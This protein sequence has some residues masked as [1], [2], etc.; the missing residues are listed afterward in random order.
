M[1]KILIIAPFEIFPP[2]WGAANR[3][4]NITKC[5]AAD[6]RVTLLYVRYRQLLITEDINDPLV[7]SKHFRV[8]GIT[9]FGKYSQIFNPL[10]I[11]TGLLLYCR[12]RFSFILAETGWSGLHALLLSSLTRIPYVIDEHNVEW[13]AFKRM[14]RG[15]KLGVSLLK[16]YE[17]I[18]C[19]LANKLIC[20]SEV[21]KEL[22]ASE[23]KIPRSKIVV[24]PNAVDLERFHPDTSERDMVRQTLGVSANAPLIL[25][26]G[27]LDYKPNYEAV[28][29]IFH[30][31]MPR[32]LKDIPNAKFLIVG[33]NPPPE[34]HHDGLIFTG[35]VDSIEDYINA[36]D[37]VICPLLSGGGTRFKILEAIACGKRVIST[38]IG[39]EA[40]IGQETEAHLTCV[41]DWDH[42]A[43]D[44]IKALREDIDTE[45][46]EGFKNKYGWTHATQVLKSRVFS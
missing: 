18:I 15:G 35:T 44:I 30:S 37:V 13:V 40:L 7:N 20:V 3:I 31:I 38:T 42:F 41:N 21:D 43:L 23:L 16:L 4:Y 6:F 12:E 25:F 8:T 27:K 45:P 19:R 34:F 5:L 39:A 2:Y 36:S 32:V 1:G 46:S 26:N 10:L 29:L 14:N 28:G 24:I 17:R 33:N 11:I 22:L 9:S